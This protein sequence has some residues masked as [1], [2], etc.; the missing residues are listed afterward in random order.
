MIGWAATFYNHS[1]YCRILGF[2]GIAGTA[3][4]IAWILFIVGLVRPSVSSLWAEDPGYK[5][6]L[7]LPEKFLPL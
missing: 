4:N 6:G 1:A 2:T 3:V 7:F 5:Q